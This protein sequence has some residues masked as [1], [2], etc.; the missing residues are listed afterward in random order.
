M[1]KARSP[2]RTGA[3]RHVRLAE[4]GH[5]LNEIGNIPPQVQQ[6]LLRVIQERTV[7]HLGGKR[8]IPIDVRVIVATNVPLEEAVNKGTF[9]KDLYYRLNQFTLWLPP[10]R[11]RKEDVPALALSFLE[12]SNR[13]FRKTVTGFSPSVDSVLKDFYWPGNI[14]QL[15]NVIK[16]AVLLSQEVVLIEHLPLEIAGGRRRE[17]TRTAPRTNGSA[18]FSTAGLDQPE[19]LKSIKLRAWTQ[20]AVRSIERRLIVEALR[21]SAQPHQSRQTAGNNRTARCIT[22]STR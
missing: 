4:G 3:T 13:E 14:R 8:E 10:L 15:K 18:D 19:N 5:F 1:K 12:E 22:N 17:D 7:Q 20:K 11:E 21:R 16:R 2:A 9:R 6:K